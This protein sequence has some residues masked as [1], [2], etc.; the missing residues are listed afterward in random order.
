MGLADRTA[1]FWRR[2]YSLKAP[3]VEAVRSTSKASPALQLNENVGTT[4]EPAGVS[5]SA[6]AP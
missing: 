6:I 2:T 5:F 1:P 3:W 4:I